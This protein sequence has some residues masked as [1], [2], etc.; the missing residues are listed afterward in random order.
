M[1]KSLIDV[2]NTLLTKKQITY[3]ILIFIGAIF[4]Y[5]LETIGLGAIAGFVLILSD[6]SVL[7]NKLP[8]GF[9]RDHISEM[10]NINLAVYCA[11]ILSIIF[12]VKNLLIFIFHYCEVHIQRNIIVNTCRRLYSYY[13]TRPYVFH[14]EK[15]P[16]TLV[17]N[18]ISEVNRGSTFFFSSLLCFREIMVVLALLTTLFFVDKKICFLIFI[19]MSFVSIIFYLLNQKKLRSLGVKQKEHSEKIIKYLYQGIGG[20]KML[21][22]SQ[23]QSFF[24]HKF[25]VE[26]DR[27]IRNQVYHYLV[28]RLPRLFLEVLAVSTVTLTTLF[29]VFSDRSLQSVIPTLTLLSLIV[30][31]TVPAF[32]NI[33]TSITTLQYNLSSITHLIKELSDFKREKDNNIHLKNKKNIEKFKSIVLESLSYQYPKTK[34]NVLKDVNL[35]I[36][37]GQMAGIIGQSGAGKSTLVDLLLGLL[38]PTKGSIKIDS[39]DINKHFSNWQKQIG[40]VAQDIYLMDDSIKKNIAFGINEAEIN[41]KKIA[42]SLQLSQL[43]D[44]VETLPNGL[45]TIIGER[46]LRLSGGQKQ[47][48]GIARALYNDPKVLIFDEA[49]SSLD[50]ETEKELI[51]EIIKLKEKKLIIMIAHRLSTLNYCDVLFLF[52]KGVLDD[53]G[54][55]NDLILRHKNLTPYLKKKNN[56]ESN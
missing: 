56:V 19:L 43:N 32:I 47:R 29:F 34:T 2:V 17:N 30:I 54:T 18:I 36:N 42:R 15:N 10:T 6:P 37:F 7:I 33:N 48:I 14:L 53:Y 25:F 20:I 40:Y 4:I 23:N 21:K 52:D 5:A 45:N 13:L 27:K 28:G 50:N 26:N 3:V 35:K 46:G 12:L 44:F 24:I 22:L 1:K 8:Y 9:F 41:D 38:T 51:N 55:I 11:V 39:L 16:T 49:T 31:R